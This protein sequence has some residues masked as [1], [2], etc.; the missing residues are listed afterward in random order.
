MMQAV[1]GNT[2][3]SILLTVS[4]NVI[5]IFTVPL[6]LTTVL[7]TSDTIVFDA[8]ELIKSLVR[9]VLLPLLLGAS[10]RALPQVQSQHCIIALQALHGQNN[11]PDTPNETI[12][13]YR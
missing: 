2:A 10:L 1:G 6:M 3:L 12:I 9:T 8:I 7:A 4:S 5:S 11:I 13:I